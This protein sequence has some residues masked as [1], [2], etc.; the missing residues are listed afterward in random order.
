ML[1]RDLV[2]LGDVE[3]DQYLDT[4]RLSGGEVNIDIEGW[5]NLSQE[6]QDDL[7]Q[8]LW[9]RTQNPRGVDLAQLNAQWPHTSADNSGSQL[10]HQ[11]VCFERSSSA[12]PP[13][14]S[15][16]QLREHDKLYYDALISLGG[17]PWYPTDCLQ[18]ISDE[19]QLG[20]EMLTSWDVEELSILYQTQF[21]KWW[22][23]C[24]WQRYVRGIPLADGYPEFHNLLKPILAQDPEYV[25]CPSDNELDAT[26]KRVFDSYNSHYY[27]SKVD[28]GFSQHVKNVKDRLEE[29]G[30]TRNFQLQED[31][32]RQDKVTTWIE[33]LSFEY[34]RQERW[35]R[36]VKRCDAAWQK[37]VDSKMLSP[38]T[39][40]RDVLY[41]FIHDDGVFKHHE[42]QALQDVKSAQ[43][44][45]IRALERTVIF[46]QKSPAR[47]RALREAALRL[48]NAQK[49]LKFLKQRSAVIEEYRCVARKHEKAKTKVERWNLFLSWIL[50]QLPFVQAELNGEAMATEPS[51][52]VFRGTKRRIH[53]YED[54]S[55]EDESLK[56]ERQ[57]TQAMSVSSGASTI[58]QRLNDL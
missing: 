18:E 40:P 51:L 58:A 54:E 52:R 55:P 12:T 24:Q 46:E 42:D 32:K 28:G 22:R 31:P 50:E 45:G 57:I 23:F 49:R 25:Q 29:H 39:K 4:T 34:W 53:W 8:R 26:V 30:F 15:E 10:L 43:K 35:A 21:R 17:R 13:P 20:Q 41:F 7:K 14:L 33:Y 19:S 3:L 27:S 48:D 9:I 2:V 6:Q 1:A 47:T 56:R 11:P 38:S 37:V 16:E 5:E 36:V 44:E